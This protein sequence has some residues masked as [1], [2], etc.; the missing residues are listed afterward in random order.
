MVPPGESTAA[1]RDHELAALRALAEAADAWARWRRQGAGAAASME[2][3][4]L[5]AALD[6]LEVSAGHAPRNLVVICSGC[7]RARDKA[8]WVE[9]ETFLTEKAG[10][11]L[12]HSLCP[13]CLGRLYP[14]EPAEP[15]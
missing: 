2:E 14:H 8:A 11:H 12:S 7:R 10:I 4:E 15:D 1:D 3:S 13:A 9:L 6:R 5:L